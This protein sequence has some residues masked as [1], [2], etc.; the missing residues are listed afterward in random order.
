[1]AMRPMIGGYGG[2][3]GGGGY[4]EEERRRREAERLAASSRGDFK[5]GYVKGTAYVGGQSR[6]EEE[7]Q[8]YVRA[9]GH[10]LPQEGRKA[11]AGSERL[12][13]EVRGIKARE[14]ASSRQQ[15]PQQQAQERQGRDRFDTPQR[16]ERQND[17]SAKLRGRMD[18]M[19]AKGMEQFGERK[20]FDNQRSF[21]T[22]RQ[23]YQKTKQD[24]DRGKFGAMAD[25][26]QSAAGNDHQQG[27]SAGMSSPA[28]SHGTSRFASMAD[29]ADAA[30]QSADQRQRDQGTNKKTG[31]EQG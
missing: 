11:R 7:Q 29:R 22:A 1:M 3:P 13:E 30:V 6:E 14:E 26:A 5:P 4:D 10:T 24:I 9:A 15:Q 25:R 21:D 17:L 28:P 16:R 2:G 12:Q 8:A 19:E 23:S 20:D 27:Q 18:A 31:L